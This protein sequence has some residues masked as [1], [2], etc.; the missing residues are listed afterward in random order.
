M[1]RAWALQN[2]SGAGLVECGEMD[3]DWQDGAPVE[4]A[5]PAAGLS[6]R[7]EKCAV[8]P[9]GDNPDARWGTKFEDLLGEKQLNE[10]VLRDVGEAT[11][12]MI[13]NLTAMQ[14]ETARRLALDPNEL[15]AGV[16]GL[17]VETDG[18][19]IVVRVTARTQGGSATSNF[20]V[21]R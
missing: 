8:E 3:I 2:L 13:D 20:Q 11:V 15:L 16:A 21:A 10:T 18:A 19:K 7:I 5:D 17:R 12:S 4:L 6:Q 14:V 9:A 1:S